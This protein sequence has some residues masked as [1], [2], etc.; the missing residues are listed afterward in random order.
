MKDKM[1]KCKSCKHLDT[2][3][4]NKN[5]TVCPVMPIEVQFLGTSN[6]CEKYEKEKK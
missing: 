2:I 1:E 6:N 3:K 4:T 5:W